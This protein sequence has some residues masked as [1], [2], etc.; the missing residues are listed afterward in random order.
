MTGLQTAALAGMLLALGLVLAVGELRPAPPSLSAAL[1][2]LSASPTAGG[3]GTTATPPSN[4]A[5]DRRTWL[6]SAVSAFFPRGRRLH[7]APGDRAS[8]RC[9]WA[10]WPG[11]C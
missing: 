3:P 8:H 4:S 6:P 2:Q 9:T 5:G 7:A 10:H 11:E 1:E